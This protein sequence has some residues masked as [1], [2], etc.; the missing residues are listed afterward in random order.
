VAYSSATATPVI[1]PLPLVTTIEPGGPAAIPPDA[2]GLQALLERAGDD[3]PV[4][5]SLR[6]VIE[7]ARQPRSSGAAFN[8]YI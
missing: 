7:A 5:R 3:T 4:G 8:N 6:R 2:A 1:A